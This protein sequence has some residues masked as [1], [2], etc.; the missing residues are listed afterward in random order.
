MVKVQTLSC[1]FLSPCLVTNY[2]GANCKPAIPDICKDRDAK[3]LTFYLPQY[4]IILPPHP[5]P[6]LVKPQTIYTIYPLQ[7]FTTLGLQYTDL[8][9]TQKVT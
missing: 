7:K 3:S 9:S 5:P 2:A 8:A 4:N 1:I 6:Y